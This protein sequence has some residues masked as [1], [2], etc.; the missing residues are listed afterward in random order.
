MEP[1]STALLTAALYE[2]GKTIAEKGIVD[3]AL[4]K[5][6]EPLRNWLTKK[7]DAKRVF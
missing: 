5:G 6:L 2:A 1:L 7:Y 3:P 4:E